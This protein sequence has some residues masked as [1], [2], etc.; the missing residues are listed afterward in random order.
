MSMTEA[1]L[2][3]ERGAKLFDRMF[4]RT[5]EHGRTTTEMWGNYIDRD[6]LDMASW[7]FCVAAQLAPVLAGGTD[8]MLGMYFTEA[9][10]VVEH[11]LGI[12]EVPES[13]ADTYSAGDWYR[14][15]GLDETDD[16]DADELQ[17]AWLDELKSRTDV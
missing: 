5:D 17:T 6:T 11:R 2:A 16:Y 15:Y 13:F 12:P 8:S 10:M 7:R 14:Y 9:I 4:T 1:R 3:V